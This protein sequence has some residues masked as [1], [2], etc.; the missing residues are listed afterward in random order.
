MKKKRKAPSKPPRR[1][2]R[3]R[4]K[5]RPFIDFASNATIAEGIADQIVKSYK[6]ASNEAAAFEKILAKLEEIHPQPKPLWRRAWDRAATF[7]RQP[8]VLHLGPCWE[9]VDQEE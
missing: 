4:I 8:I 6:D 9:H 3:K 1:R 5:P 7:L 2:S